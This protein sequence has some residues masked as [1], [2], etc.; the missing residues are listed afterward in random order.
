[1][2]TEAL[3]NMIKLVG[4]TPVERDTLYTVFKDYSDYQ[5][6]PKKD[7]TSFDLPVI[8]K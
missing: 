2:T 8:D 4:R 3:V 6:T 1:M 5:F 7:I